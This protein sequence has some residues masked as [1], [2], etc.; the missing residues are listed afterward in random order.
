[1]PEAERYLLL[2]LAF[3]IK[4]GA[5]ILLPAPFF[6]VDTGLPLPAAVHASRSSLNRNEAYLS[7]IVAVDFTIGM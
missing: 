4:D 5:E 1:L 3:A 7:K 6:L 2:S